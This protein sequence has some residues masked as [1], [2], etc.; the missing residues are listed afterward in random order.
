MPPGNVFSPGDR[1]RLY[2]LGTPLDQLPSVPGLDTVLLGGTTGTR[3]LLPGLGAP[4]F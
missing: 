3:L 2:I 4:Q 1:I